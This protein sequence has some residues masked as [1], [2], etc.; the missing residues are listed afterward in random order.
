MEILAEYND[1]Y[2]ETVAFLFADVL[3]ELRFI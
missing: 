2:F 1:L 3:E